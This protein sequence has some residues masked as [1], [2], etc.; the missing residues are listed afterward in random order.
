VPITFVERERGNS[1]MNGSIVRESL[2]RVT[3]WGAR[4]RADQLKA[5]T[6]RGSAASAAGP[7]ARS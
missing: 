6:R 4:H 5:L 3:L 7:N 1:K 2:T